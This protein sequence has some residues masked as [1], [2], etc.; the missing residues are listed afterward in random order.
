LDNI[1]RIVDTPIAYGTVEVTQNSSY[2]IFYYAINNATVYVH[3]F[4]SNLLEKIR[5]HHRTL[6]S[7]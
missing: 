7:I 5:F 2:Y 6:F 1:C 4:S 3:I